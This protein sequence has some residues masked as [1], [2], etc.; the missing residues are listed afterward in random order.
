MTTETSGT[1]N[2]RPREL[3][4]EEF[5]KREEEKAGAEERGARWNDYLL[6][7]IRAKKR[8]AASRAEQQSARSA[9]TACAAN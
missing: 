3:S 8:I 6:R 2:L 4:P 1:L 5:V 7:H 9:D